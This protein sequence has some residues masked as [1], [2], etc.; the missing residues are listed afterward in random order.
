M[1][2]P[3]SY[4]YN[5]VQGFLK[6]INA[7]IFYFVYS[8]MAILFG[9]GILFTKTKVTVLYGFVDRTGR[10]VKRIQ[11]HEALDYSEGMAAVYI[12][13]NECGYIGTHGKIIIPPAY[14]RC[15]SFKHGRA[16][17]AGRSGAGII[18][19]DGSWVIEPSYNDLRIFNRGKFISNTE[20]GYE[21]LDSKEM[22]VA[23]LNAK[24]IDVVSENRAIVF[25]NDGGTGIINA[26]GSVIARYHYNF[27]GRCAENMCG[28]NEDLF[29]E[30][31]WGYMK[32]SGEIMVPAKYETVSV[33]SEGVAFVYD[34]ACYKYINM[35][36]EVVLNDECYED[37]SVFSEGL[38]AVKKDG[39]WK[40]VDRLGNVIHETRYDSIMPFADGLAVVR[41][42]DRECAIN[43]EFEIIVPCV[44]HNIYQFNNGI[45]RVS[46][47]ISI[48]RRREGCM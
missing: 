25:Y 48:T 36:G 8:S 46:N 18:A 34:G 21:I 29:G 3:E 5:T 30:T 33:F 14:I 37:A 35:K 42:N 19:R 31:L 10:F 20:K 32:Y 47:E 15:Q 24:Q 4:V 26:K 6:M 11:Y 9:C 40:Y 28:Y 16:V 44:F 22:T 12:K 27:I 38:A 41:S 39:K 43:R 1:N 2:N 23:K 45:A 7:R 13:A 17:V